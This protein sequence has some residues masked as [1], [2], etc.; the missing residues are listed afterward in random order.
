M[1][2]SQLSKVISRWLTSFSDSA[3]AEFNELFGLPC[4]FHYCQVDINYPF[5]HVAAE[6]WHPSR[7][8]FR[9]NCNEVCPTIEDFGGILGRISFN[10][11]L[12]PVTEKVTADEVA[13]FLGLSTR[14][15]KQW[16]KDFCIDIPSL[17]QYFINRPMPTGEA[18]VFYLRAACIC[19]LATLFFLEEQNK[20]ETF[21]IRSLAEIRSFNPSMM[22][23]AGTLKG[24]D[25][26]VRTESFSF[27]GSPLLLQVPDKTPDFPVHHFPFLCFFFWNLLEC[28]YACFICAYV[29]LKSAYAHLTLVFLFL[30]DLVV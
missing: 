2:A 3:K 7:H 19:A 17:S 8:V 12:M 9:F 29:Y 20:I 21:I 27:D 26:V 16:V 4:I 28:A 22:I 14:L 25:R 1:E 30:A 23:L 15:V 18:R 10:G 13:R 5:L 6:F 11:L 24:L